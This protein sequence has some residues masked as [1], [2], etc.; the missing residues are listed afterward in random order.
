MVVIPYS[1]EFLLNEATVGKV[2][3]YKCVVGMDPSWKFVECV[4]NHQ[5]GQIDL[6]MDDGK[7]ECSEFM[8]IFDT[9]PENTV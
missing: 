2:S 3:H 8:P 5:T 6:I 9:L 7:E 4:W 1:P